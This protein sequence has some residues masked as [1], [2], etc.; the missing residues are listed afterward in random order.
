MF[1]VVAKQI[2]LR[3]NKVVFGILHW[4]AEKQPI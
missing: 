1:A 3:R 4:L 2:W